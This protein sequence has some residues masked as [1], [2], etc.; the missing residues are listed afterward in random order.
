MGNL[1]IKGPTSSTKDQISELCVRG[2][3]CTRAIPH[4]ACTNLQERAAKG[5]H[6]CHGEAQKG[7]QYFP[8]SA[9]LD[10]IKLFPLSGASFLLSNAGFS[11]NTRF[12]V[13]ST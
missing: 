10:K 11:N 5:A 12:I 1:G 7:L 4:E 8:A 6:A 2:N 9:R 3:R 13:G